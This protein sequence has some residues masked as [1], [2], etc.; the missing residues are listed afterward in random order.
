M[1]VLS[2]ARQEGRQEHIKTRC[3]DD[4]SEK[5]HIGSNAEVLQQPCFQPRFISKECS[6][7]CLDQSMPSSSK[8][9]PIRAVS[10][11]DAGTARMTP[12]SQNLLNIK[13][14]SA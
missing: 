2:T 8:A 14:C 7:E 13:Q 5:T 3:A 6:K 11:A 1:P 9:Q 10:T 12:Q 4:S